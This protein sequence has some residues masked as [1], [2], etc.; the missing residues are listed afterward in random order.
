VKQTSSLFRNTLIYGLTNIFLKSAGFLLLPFYS[1]FIAPSEFGVFSVLIAGYTI[2]VSFYQGGFQSSFSKFYLEADK[3]EDK[4]A[5]MTQFFSLTMIVSLFASL[6]CASAA[7]RLSVLLFATPAYQNMIRIL[8]LT[9]FFDNFQTCGL[10]VF[11]T[12]E[13]AKLV[14]YYSFVPAVINV[15][16]SLF[17]MISFRQ[18]ILAIINAQFLSVFIVSAMLLKK[19]RVYFSFQFERKYIIPFINFA[20][21]LMLAGGFTALVDLADRFILKL[22]FDDAAVGIY[23]FSYRIANVMMLFVISFRTAW[24]PHALK[25]YKRED[26]AEHFG[27]SFLK[28]LFLSTTLFLC[29]SIFAPLLF[30]VPLS[31]N[32]YFF[33]PAYRDGLPII[34]IILLAYLFNGIIAFYSVYP[35]VSGKSYHFLISDGIAV[36][37]NILGNVLL[38]PR[39]GLVGAAF[40]TFLSYLFSMIYLWAISHNKI[41]V[42][43]DV[44]K[45]L[46]FTVIAMAVFMVS[47]QYHNP[48]VIVLLLFIY[49]YWGIRVMGFTIIP[50]KAK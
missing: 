23:S 3:E 33:N 49:L 46:L 25:L 35:Y 22:Y 47:T 34:P 2:V 8:A 13:D 15:V 14:S 4:E 36:A 29:V 5:I 17:L 6:V 32:I 40:A 18:G 10:H 50:K 11:K 43:L 41:R 39:F 31:G 27:R 19:L 12:K 1:H 9:L 38:I 28:M 30:A 44:R 37:V 48:F 45:I 24:T 7:D 20:M 21:P 42:I 26:Y 16:L